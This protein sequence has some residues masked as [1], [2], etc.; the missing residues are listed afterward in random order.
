[1]TWRLVRHSHAVRLYRQYQLVKS[2]VVQSS[3]P[4]PRRLS[5][6]TGSAV[7]LVHDATIALSNPHSPDTVPKLTTHATLLRQPPG[8]DV[9]VRIAGNVHSKRTHKK[10]AFLFVGDGS[11]YEP[12][13][14]VL[15]PGDV[16]V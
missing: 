7:P 1:M 4:I 16:S 11:T 2:S 9:S 6:T 14:A 15:E 5:T 3:L 12:I 13:Q 10:V 8:Q